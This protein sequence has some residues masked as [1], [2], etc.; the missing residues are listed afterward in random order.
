VSPYSLLVFLN[1]NYTSF[2]ILS[3]LF[4]TLQLFFPF[5]QTLFLYSSKRKN[6]NKVV[7]N[8]TLREKKTQGGVVVER[9]IKNI[10]EHKKSVVVVKKKKTSFKK[11]GGVGGGDSKL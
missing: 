8:F 4:Q 7:S 2:H 3:S 11:G 5:F 10:R 6:T 9:G 1:L